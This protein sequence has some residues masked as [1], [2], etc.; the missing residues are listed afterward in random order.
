MLISFFSD[1]L[2]CHCRSLPIQQT[3][4]ASDFALPSFSLAEERD[5]AHLQQPSSYFATHDHLD[6]Q[7]PPSYFPTPTRLLDIIIHRFGP[8]RPFSSDSTPVVGPDQHPIE[9]QQDSRI[10]F[11]QTIEVFSS[12]DDPIL[13][14]PFDLD[15]EPPP[16]QYQQSTELACTAAAPSPVGS[17]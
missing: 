7:Q 15:G 9:L 5:H 4:E 14:P 8:D 2:R 11:T 12:G 3:H 17:V 1:L 10:T 6:H 13:P 16:Y